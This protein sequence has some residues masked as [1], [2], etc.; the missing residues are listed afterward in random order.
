MSKKK[1]KAN[2]ANT[3]PPTPIRNMPTTNRKPS[4]S[5]RTIRNPRLYALGQI[6]KSLVES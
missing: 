3:T 1:A 6:G 2:V 4:M 5:K